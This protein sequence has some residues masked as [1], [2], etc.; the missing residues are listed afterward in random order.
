M[1][2]GAVVSVVVV[3]LVVGGK[4]L[5]GVVAQGVAGVTP[6]GSKNVEKVLLGLAADAEV[7]VDGEPL[8]P[9]LVPHHHQ[10]LVLL[11]VRQPMEL[12]KADE[13]LAVEDPEAGF[14]V[15]PVAIK[16]LAAVE[17]VGHHQPASLLVPVGNF[18]VADDEEGLRVVAD[19]Y[20]DLSVALAQAVLRR[21]VRNGVEYHGRGRLQASRGGR[22]ELF[23]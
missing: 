10:Q 20:P 8:L 22:S 1:S 6:V 5:A 16:F 17:P 9:L 12:V 21:F 15:L 19:S 23:E 4:L 14:V 2:P 11:A 7:V 3:I 13:E 18:L